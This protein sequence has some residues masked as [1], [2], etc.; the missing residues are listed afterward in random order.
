VLKSVISKFF[1]PK[2]KKKGDNS[3]IICGCCKVTEQ[4]VKNAID[5]GAKSYS[6]V[7]AATKLGYGCGMCNGN[8]KILVNELLLR[9]N[10]R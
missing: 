8:N 9:K 6:E 2:E 10:F 4:D 3:K 7:Q 1:K 5:N